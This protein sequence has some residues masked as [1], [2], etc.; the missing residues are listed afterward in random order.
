MIRF[1]QVSVE[2]PLL[3]GERAVALRDIDLEIRPGEFVALMGLNGSGKSTLAR[4]C[5]GLVAPTRGR[6]VI[7]GFELTADNRKHVPDI[8]RR[9][10]MVFQNPDNQL[11]S[12]TVEREI[13][14]GLENLGVAPAEMRRRVETVLKTFHLMDYRHH[15]PHRLSGG[16]KQRVALAAIMVMQP[17]YLIL[18]E[19]TSLLDYQHQKRLMETILAMHQDKKNLPHTILHITQFPH[20]AL[21][22]TRLIILHNG[23]IYLDGSPKSVFLQED[24]LR[25]IGLEAPLE[26]SAYRLLRK[27]N[28]PIKSVEELILKPIL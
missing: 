8:R 15:P 14:F 2:Y 18:D 25:A 13:A 10:G 1:E 20:E 11:V 28:Y 22:A 27:K 5:N 17:A 6:V 26:F 12:T 7:D 4:V 21:L 16:E 24:R 3:Q 9:V 23:Q 19:P